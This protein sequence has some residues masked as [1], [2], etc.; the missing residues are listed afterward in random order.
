MDGRTV[1]GIELL[2]ALSRTAP[3]TPSPVAIVGGGGDFVF[4]GSAAAR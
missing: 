4:R 3:S 2:K 1:L